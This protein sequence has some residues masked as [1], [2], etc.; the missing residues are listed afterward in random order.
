MPDEMWRKLIVEHSGPPA[1]SSVHP[2]LLAEELTMS[3]GP[4]TV[5]KG[6]SFELRPG[7]VMGFL[8]PNG[9]G[10]TTSIRILT[11]IL[12]STSPEVLG[13]SSRSLLL[14]S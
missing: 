4:R 9:A 14:S 6:L 1:T 8:G 13:W 2:A 5:L 7:H 12:R 10:K 11:T 3:Y